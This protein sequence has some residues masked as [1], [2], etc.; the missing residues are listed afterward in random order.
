MAER[1]DRHNRMKRDRHHGAASDLNEAKQAEKS[2]TYLGV[3]VTGVTNRNRM[4]WDGIDIIHI[5]D[6]VDIG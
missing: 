1:S 5:W 2:G 4:V 3:E 6:K